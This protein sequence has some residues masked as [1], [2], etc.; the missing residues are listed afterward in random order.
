MSRFVRPTT[1]TLTLANGDQLIVRERLT[2]GEQ[3]AHL[4]RL[5]R[6]DAD[7]LLQRDPLMLRLAI[8]L[9]Y[10]LDWNLRD[11]AGQ[12]VP[13]RDL[14]AGDLQQVIDSLETESF[15]EI[16]DAIN[17]H[18]LAMG[19]EREQQKKTDGASPSLATS[20]SLVASA[21]GTNG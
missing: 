4:A 11:D 2:A 21:G 8:V 12:A 9:A 19:A 10:L 20:L 7:G 15:Q 6:T 16:Y 14:S 18:D 13:I 5:Y 17:T 3:R 1:R